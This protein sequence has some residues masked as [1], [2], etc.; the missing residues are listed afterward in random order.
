[1]SREQARHRVSAFFKRLVSGG[2]G[3]MP[4]R[5]ETFR[6][7]IGGSAI[8]KA[9]SHPLAAEPARALIAQLAAMAAPRDLRSR[10]NHD[11]VRDFL[12]AG[13]RRYSRDYFVQNVEH[14]RPAVSASRG[15]TGHRIAAIA[16]RLCF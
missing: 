1:M 3:P 10:R 4:L 5:I 2:A 8:Y 12:S 7:D 6:N 11:A 15:A 14:L 9:L 13:W 16:L